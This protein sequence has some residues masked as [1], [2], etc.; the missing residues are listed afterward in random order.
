MSQSTDA[1]SGSYSV[2]VG[3]STSANKRIGY[4]EMT[5]KAGDYVIKF[6][7][8]AASTTGATVCP[9]AVNVVDGKVNGSYL[10]GDYVNDITSAEWV[11]VEQTVKIPSDGTYCFVIMNSKK[12]GGDVLID[13]YTVT[14]NGTS[15]IK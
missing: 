2:K 10:Y 5:L 9:G 8:K 14:L 11:L 7:A 3:G 12:P 6:Y 15:I 4:K 1:H 13:D